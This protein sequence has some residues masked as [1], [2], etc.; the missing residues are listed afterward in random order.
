V[1]VQSENLQQDSLASY[2]LLKQQLIIKTL[3][4]T[5]AGGIISGLLLGGLEAAMCFTTGGVLSVIYQWLLQQGVDAAVTS[6]HTSNA[7]Q[8]VESSRRDQSGLPSRTDGV[9]RI[10]GHPA[11][12]LGLLAVSVSLA[13]SNAFNTLD[14]DTGISGLA[15]SECSTLGCYTG[16]EWFARTPSPEGTRNLFLGFLGFM[17]FKVAVLVEAFSSPLTPDQVVTDQDIADSM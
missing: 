15:V 9:Q 2:Q 6:G 5:G 12:R 10:L 4:I 16:S 7:S 8:A 11:L 1:Q 14:P 17:S 13:A 3:I